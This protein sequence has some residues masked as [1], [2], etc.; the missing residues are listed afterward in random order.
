MKG[1]QRFGVKKKLATRYVGPC[2]IIERKGEVAYRIQLPEDMS[3]IFPVFHVSQLK[4]CLR[5]LK[6][7]VEAKDL[8]IGSDLVHQEQPIKILDTKDRIT[9]NSTIKTYKVLW[10][11][12][13]EC[14][15]MWETDAYLCEVYTT[16]TKKWLVTLKS[17]SEIPLSGEYC[18]TPGV[19]HIQTF[20]MHH[21]SIIMS[22]ISE[23]E[24]GLHLVPN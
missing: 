3:T 17:R 20:H 22:I 18:N 15:A 1:I 13:D 11:H 2:Q 21:E 5:V 14:D 10:S 4:K 12:H 9:R 24:L 6:E 19:K 16:F 8:K 23:R 7:R